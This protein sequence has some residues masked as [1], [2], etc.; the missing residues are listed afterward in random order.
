[1]PSSKIN[2]PFCSSSENAM[3][4]PIINENLDPIVE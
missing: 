4:N 1:M 2:N 3:F